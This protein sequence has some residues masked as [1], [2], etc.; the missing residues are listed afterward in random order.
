MQH[1]STST[2]SDDLDALA[3]ASGWSGQTEDMGDVHRLLQ[4]AVHVME[5]HANVID[6]AGVERQA[7]RVFAC[8]VAKRP[9]TWAAGRDDQR[10]R[11]DVADLLAEDAADS[12]E[13]LRD[14]LRE[15]LGLTS[16]NHDSDED[17]LE[18]VDATLT[19]Y[20]SALRAR[21][22]QIAMLER[23]VMYHEM[24]AAGA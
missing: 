21:R 19:N 18:R 22:Q 12:A 3:R 16:D 11:D 6:A 23:E 9:E 24:R 10:L 4:H 20:K 17:L 14:G 1:E 13:E 7:W 8:A 15:M 5:D 2:V